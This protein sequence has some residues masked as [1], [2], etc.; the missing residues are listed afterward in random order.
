[1]AAAFSIPIS[2]KPA[3]SIRWATEDARI[4]ICRPAKRD[5]LLAINTPKFL[6]WSL[7]NACRDA[8]LREITAIFMAIYVCLSTNIHAC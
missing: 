3:A 7:H 4:R 6:N 5:Y 1:L 2:A 8:V